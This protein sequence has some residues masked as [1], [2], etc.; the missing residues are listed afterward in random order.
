MPD[1]DGVEVVRR[2]R[3]SRSPASSTPVV[4][5]TADAR[6][7][8]ATKCRE[9]GMVGWLTKPLMPEALERALEAAVSSVP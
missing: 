3:V 8:T 6:P 5:L 2:L 9:A 7:E 4:A 1:M